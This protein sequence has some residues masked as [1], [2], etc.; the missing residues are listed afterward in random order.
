MSNEWERQGGGERKEVYNLK[1]LQDKW[2]Y[3]SKYLSNL[4]CLIWAQ[5]NVWEG[6]QC[7]ENVFE[8]DEHLAFL[9]RQLIRSRLSI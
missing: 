9:T 2:L 7:G 5:D 3:L 4:H 6:E 1:G 8:F